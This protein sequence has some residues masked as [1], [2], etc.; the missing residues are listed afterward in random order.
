MTRSASRWA[1]LG[2][3]VVVGLLAYGGFRLLARPGM[4]AD[5][6]RA[7]G[8]VARLEEVLGATDGAGD[9]GAA[10]AEEMA[11]ELAG[12]RERVAALSGILATPGEAE[13]VLH[14]LGSLASDAGVRFLRFAPEPEF[15][16]GGYRTRA[17]SVV[18]EGTFF[19]FLTFF[20]RVSL[21]PQLVLIEDLGLEAA[22]GGLIR[23]RFA[24][25]TVGAAEPPPDAAPGSFSSGNSSGRPLGS[26][27]ARP[28]DGGSGW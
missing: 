9:A 12:T 13:A 28:E 17:A 14:S 22:R 16:L 24:A 7:E 6:S 18:A 27:P 25:V 11:N 8:E 1:P 15:R 2:P 10:A 4:V 3:F 23:C 21:L 26:R 5:L 19:D 20:E